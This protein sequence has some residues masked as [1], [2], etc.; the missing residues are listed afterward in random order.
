MLL[1]GVAIVPGEPFPLG[2]LG[3]SD[4][5]DVLTPFNWQVIFAALRRHS[6]RC[7]VHSLL[8]AC[9]LNQ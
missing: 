9:D 8:L 7:L 4:D 5:A 1:T 6:Y 3:C 2:A